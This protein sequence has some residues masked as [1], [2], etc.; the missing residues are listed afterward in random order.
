M[1]YENHAHTAGPW[2]VTIWAQ[3]GQ[4]PSSAGATPERQA[5]V[6]DD[7]EGEAG[8]DWRQGRGPRTA[9]HVSD[10]R[11]GCSATTVQDHPSPDFTARPSVTRADMTIAASAKKEIAQDPMGWSARIRANSADS[12][13]RWP[14]LGRE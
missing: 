5:L 13:L 12:R 6:A 4:L 1:N 11:G 2:A 8:Q 3:P 14:P 9:C 10:G 7:V